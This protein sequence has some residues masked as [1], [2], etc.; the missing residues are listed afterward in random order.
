[1]PSGQGLGYCHRDP[2]GSP[3]GTS[4]KQGEGAGL[5]PLLVAPRAGGV[6]TPPPAFHLQEAPSTVTWHAVTPNTVTRR[7]R[8]PH[9]P[10]PGALSPPALSP[11]TITPRTVTPRSHPVESPRGPPALSAATGGPDS[12]PGTPYALLSHGFSWE[13]MMW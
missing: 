6:W 4:R 3:G 13:V 11:G 1:M 10:S 8:S 7:A 12:Q 2:R 9:A 5:G